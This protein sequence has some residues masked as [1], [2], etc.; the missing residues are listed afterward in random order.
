MGQDAESE[1]SSRPNAVIC[2]TLSRHYQSQLGLCAALE[3]I[4]D[5][6]PNDVNKQKC[7]L[8]AQSISSIIKSA[9]DYEEAV[10]FPALRGAEQ[11]LSPIG[12][13]LE[14]LHAEHCEDESFG[15]EVSDALQELASGQLE[16]VD[17][18]SYML[19]GFFEGLR[20]HIAFE[21]EYLLPLLD[22]GR[23]TS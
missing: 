19:R 2:E 9:H 7:Q 13:N 16:N 20:R 8:A 22:Q 12:T 6:L 18:L 1:N 15:E 4:A 10:L 14:R 11:D 5:S 23:R 21:Q 17:K 3:D